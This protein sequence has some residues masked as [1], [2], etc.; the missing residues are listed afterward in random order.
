MVRCEPEGRASNH[1][2]RRRKATAVGA[3]RTCRR[4]MVHGEGLVEEPAG[5]RQADQEDDGRRRRMSSE[6][7]HR[8]GGAEI[9]LGGLEWRTHGI[10]LRYS[11]ASR[12]MASG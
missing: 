3:T 10:S 9:F 5:Q 4:S 1:A 11:A 12:T 6:A 8:P 7:V 2:R